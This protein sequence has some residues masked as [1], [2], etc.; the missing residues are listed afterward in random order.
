[1]SVTL[2]P[3][4]VEYVGADPGG[5]PPPDLTTV[6]RGSDNFDLTFALAFAVDS[7]G[8][9]FQPVW[10]R[11]LTP[12]LIS[13]VNQSTGASFVASLAGANSP[14]QD[15]SD[16]DS[17]INNATS[18]LWNL[19]GTYKLAG[20]DIDYEHGVDSTFATAI[21]QV[22]NNL[23]GM[24]SLLV[25]IAPYRRTWPVYQEVVSNVGPDRLSINY[26]AYGDGLTDQQSYL[27]LYAELAQFIAS[28]PPANLNPP[29][30]WYGLALGIDSST[31]APRGLQ[32]PDIYSV[33]SSLK[34][35]G[36]H[37]AFVWCAEYSAASGFPIESDIVNILSG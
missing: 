32:P 34:G 18:S 9:N 13:Q 21:S 1:M 12:S 25:S 4:L 35:N 28:V 16:V 2:A 17:W 29:G 26:Q 23:Y 11:S 14:W 7:G 3:V 15:P 10:N 31:T 24:G 5:T 36:I 30:G 22:I 6:P 20:I 8:G 33:L 37:G 27:A 19:I